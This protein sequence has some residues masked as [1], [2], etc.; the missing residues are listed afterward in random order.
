MPY[1]PT[2]REEN[3]MDQPKNQEIVPLNRELYSDLSIDELEQRLELGC[4]IWICYC[5]YYNECDTQGCVAQFCLVQ[6]GG[7]C[8]E[9]QQTQ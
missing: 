3:Q 7:S 6:G 5:Q 4:W 9:A 8:S 1:S 2:K